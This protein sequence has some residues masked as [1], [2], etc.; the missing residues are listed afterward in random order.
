MLGYRH[1]FHAGNHGD[2]L[3]HLVLVHLLDYLCAKDKPWW[4][5][6]THAGAGR[7]AL[8]RGFATQLREHEHGIDRLWA[9]A[10]LPAAITRYLDLVRALN[11]G[12]VLRHYPGSPWLARACMRDQDRL[13]LH[14]L[15]P[16]DFALLEKEF[17]GDDRI[18]VMDSDGFAT[19]KSHLPPQPRRALVMLDPSYELKTDYAQLVGT[20]RDA[21]TRFP[22]GVYMAWYPLLA[23]RESRELPRR[24]A[25]IGERWL[26]A[27]LAVRDASAA[28]GL[29][30]SGV[31]V[32]NPPYT[33]MGMLE[34]VMPL[35]ER[36]LGEDAHASFTLE[37]SEG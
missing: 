19:L 22:T 15:H 24:L 5:V 36:L 18:R 21:M 35:L 7:Y 3:K 33:L 27:A 11:H 29:Y 25:G 20:L 37:Q 6:D 31:F 2:V 8:K 9:E 34:E 14:E 1:A 32:I 26:H 23:R 30:G 28:P 16:T 13:W 12:N 17:A 4:Y 10:D